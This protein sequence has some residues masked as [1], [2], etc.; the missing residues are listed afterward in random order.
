[1][2]DRLTGVIGEQEAVGTDRVAGLYSLARV[3]A[4]PRGGTRLGSSRACLRRND[5]IVRSDRPGTRRQR[6]SA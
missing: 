4:E 3:P 1:M 5:L 2:A 6:C